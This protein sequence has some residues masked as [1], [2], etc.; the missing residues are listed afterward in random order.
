MIF[1]FPAI[2]SANVDERLL[3]GLL[4][5]LEKYY[6]S[7]LITAIS[8][9]AIKFIINVD[10]N[11][12]A[13]TGISLE[14]ENIDISNLLLEVTRGVTYAIPPNSLTHFAGEKNKLFQVPP[15]T[16]D[17]E[18]SF[19]ATRGPRSLSR[20]QPLIVTP[21]ESET[22]MGNHHGRTPR[23]VDWYD[24]IE[25]VRG[26]DTPEGYIRGPDNAI[27]RSDQ[28]DEYNRMYSGS[29]SIKDAWSDSLVK[30]KTKKEKEEFEKQQQQN[31]V[32]KGTKAF[33]LSIDNK[34]DFVPTMV[35]LETDVWIRRD[36][37]TSIKPQQRSIAVGVKV[38]PIK[39][40]NFSNMYRTIRDDYFASRYRYLYKTLGRMVLR[41]LW[42]GAAIRKLKRWYELAVGTNSP[43]EL[44]SSKLDWYLNVLLSKKALID[45]GGFNPAPGGLKYRQF[46]SG[47]AIMNK[48]EKED[49]FSEPGRLQRLFN[50]G[51]NS[52]VIIDPT[53]HTATFCSNL[54]RGKCETVLL[55]QIFHSM[56]AENIYKNYEDLQ[57]SAGGFMR[58]IQSSPITMKQVLR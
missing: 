50:M 25:Q 17:I 45:S 9:Y 19:Y 26:V 56:N 30:F 43:D 21:Y 4:K 36:N 29:G 34:L 44:G 13:A 1:T 58:K 39:S 27:L 32:G 8:N 40:K 23:I 24:E 14:S 54:D 41:A 48:D 47:I 10:T 18:S 51:W 20:N 22:V 38:I 53:Q 11:N 37:V 28:L 15:L 42:S 3:P 57:R 52:F 6:L 31:I 12:G 2:I 46:T 55:S 35:I 33:S 16:G 49:M 7:H 5:V